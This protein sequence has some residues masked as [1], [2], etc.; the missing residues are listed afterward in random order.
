MNASRLIRKLAFALLV[1]SP[2]QAVA[3]Q[4]SPQVA[5]SIRPVQALVYAVT[6]TN[7]LPD[8]LLPPGTSPHAFALKP[9]QAQILQD[10][11]IIFWVGPSLET[12]LQGALQNLG[13]KARVVQLIDTPGLDLLH[14]ET[15]AHQ[16]HDHGPVDPH[17]WLS[18]ANAAVLIDRIQSELTTV[19]PQHAAIYA[20]NA[21]VAKNRLK[22]LEIGRAHV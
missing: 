22:L 13:A 4:V 2:M 11:E 6:G 9:S 19:A 1:L 8:V 21:K 20:K 15:E 12:A 7:N 10:A 5:T 18:P 14:Y 16:D 3:G 17:V